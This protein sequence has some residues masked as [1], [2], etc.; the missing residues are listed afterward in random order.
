[1]EVWCYQ[2]QW[3]VGQQIYADKST[4]GLKLLYSPT[5]N[6]ASPSRVLLTKGD[7]VYTV[8]NPA[9]LMPMLYPL[10]FISRDNSQLKDQPSTWLLVHPLCP[11]PSTLYR[12]SA[13]QEDN[14]D[15]DLMVS[16]VL[17]EVFS[18]DRWSEGVRKAGFTLLNCVLSS[19]QSM[20]R[21]CERDH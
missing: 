3:H 14:T 9:V 12:F 15:V 7:A 20:F 2:V 8:Y 10:G 13:I 17:T 4:A 11:H 6:P 5:Q 16:H 21:G 18:T 1:M 19:L